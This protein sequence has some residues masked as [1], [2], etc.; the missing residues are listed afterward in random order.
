MTAMQGCM[1]ADESEKEADDDWS[2]KRESQMDERM[3]RPTPPTRPLAKATT[4][5]TTTKE[6]KKIDM[7]KV[8]IDQID[9]S[10]AGALQNS[11][12]MFRDFLDHHVVAQ[13]LRREWAWDERLS[14]VIEIFIQPKVK[15]AISIQRRSL[16]IISTRSCSQA[17]GSCSTRSWTSFVR[18]S[19]GCQTQS[20]ENQSTG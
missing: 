19:P 3:N 1:E 8:S 16:R 7:Y 10:S 4:T 15:H 12:Y 20:K 17:T 2:P 14:H 13:H 5:T 6:T 18:S 9:D 11:L